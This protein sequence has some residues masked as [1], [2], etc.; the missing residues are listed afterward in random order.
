MDPDPDDWMMVRRDD[1]DRLTRDLLLA[2]ARHE[3]ARRTYQHAAVALTV[4]TLVLLVLVVRAVVV[5]FG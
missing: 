1:F 4:V 2:T 5:M 3:Q